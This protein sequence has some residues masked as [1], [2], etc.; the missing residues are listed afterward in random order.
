M[1][2][3]KFGT[4]LTLFLAFALLL[5]GCAGSPGEA[6][7]E[8]KER[9]ASA[10]IMKADGT[11]RI[12]SGSENEE[13]EAVIDECSQATGVEIEMDYKGSVDIMRAL[14][15]GAE[16]YD[17]VWP[18]SSI[19]LSMGDVDH[20]VKHSQ[21][22]SMTPVVFGIR[23][24]LAEELGFKG[25]DVSVK[26]ILAAI[27]GGKMS[28]CMTSATQSN[29]G[30]SAYIG[31]L[32]ALLGKQ[33]GMTAEDLQGEQLRADITEL[34]GGVERSSGSSDWLK[35]L[36]LKEDYDA[37]VNYECLIIDANRQL[38]SEGKEPLYIVYPYDGLSIAD[39]PLG[40]VDHG[41]SQ[42]EEA[43]QAVQQYLLSKEA[44]SEIEAT[45]R[46]ISANGVSDENKDVFNEEWGVDT[47]RI[48]SPIQMPDADVL[49]EALNLYQTSFKKPSLNIYCLDFSG[50]MEGTGEAQLK[51][52]MSQIL[53]QENASRNFLQANAG[54]VNEVIFFDNTILDIERAADDSDEALAQLY[55]KVADFQIAGGTDIY[56]AAAQALAEAS[57]YDLEKYT[58]AIILMT[59]G[60]S[61]YNYQT[62]QEA[63]DILGI[64]VPV[65]S[66]TFGA[67]DPTQ[68]E[69]L[70]E[71]TGGRVFDGT[72]DLTEAFRSVK[73]YN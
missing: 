66:I 70:A 33:E 37:M 53:L 7:T 22:I 15:S 52:A 49:M 60:V 38:E 28:F 56:N 73:G 46:R 45:G 57:S 63:W 5:T 62:F 29:S 16:E 21:S 50:S 35:D 26:D 65:F 54:E 34:L 61:D 40:Y 36:F 59:D 32:Y 1:R 31:F 47:E 39:S 51:D 67:A 25:K 18:A 13:L 68:L 2:K 11:I 17:A 9:D 6:K 69:E 43:F 4:A 44:Q 20:L 12:L 23:D 42:K 3:R 24:S 55:Q 48:L 72:Q 30:A 71:A 19:W 8:E 27:Q 64:D 58:P 10:E 14:E 41:D